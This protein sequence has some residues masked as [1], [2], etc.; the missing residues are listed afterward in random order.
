MK[1]KDEERCFAFFS[2]LFVF[3]ALFLFVD[4]VL[5]EDLLAFVVGGVGSKEVLI[6]VVC[7]LV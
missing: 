4:E 7:S 6:V 1:G 3:V 2:F 5:F